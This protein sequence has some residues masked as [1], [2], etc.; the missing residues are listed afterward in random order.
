[1]SR[2]VPEWIGTTDDTPVPPRVRVR[3][4]DRDGGRCQCG[5]GRKILVGEAWETHHVV[6]LIAGGENREANLAT[7]LK[8]HHA[9]QTK[10]DVAAK[11]KSYAVRSRHLGVKRKSRSI[12]GSK[13]SGWKRK[14]DGTVERR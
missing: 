6:P 8:A 14:M 1:M 13:A 4:F 11:A 9:K 12:P 10:A 7:L 5:C 2:T 3:V